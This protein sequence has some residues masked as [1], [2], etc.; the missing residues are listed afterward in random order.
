MVYLLTMGKQTER[1]TRLQEK[2]QSIFDTFPEI[3]IMYI[4]QLL[5]I[6]RGHI[7]KW[8]E[9]GKVTRP[10]DLAVGHGFR[11]DGE[12][13]RDKPGKPVKR[14]RPPRDGGGSVTPGRPVETPSRAPESV[15]PPPKDMWE[16]LPDYSVAELRTL[17]KKQMGS[18]IRNG[19]EVSSYAQALKALMEC[20]VKERA[21]GLDD[22]EVMHSYVPDEDLGPGDE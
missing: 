7:H 11:Y 10:P 20:D 1:V 21:L 5:E 8:I 4:E 18:A 16:D 2:V 12:I 15:E 13:L 9:R 22:A 19:K 17:V 6:R 3:P 14:G